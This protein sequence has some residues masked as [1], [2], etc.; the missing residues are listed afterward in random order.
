ME[1]ANNAV[2]ESVYVLFI[3]YFKMKY[4]FKRISMNTLS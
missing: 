3:S 1:E 2:N 4:S